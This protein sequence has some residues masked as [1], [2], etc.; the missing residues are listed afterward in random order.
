MSVRNTPSTRIP[1][2]VLK[3]QPSSTPNSARKCLTGIPTLIPNRQSFQLEQQN[4]NKRRE[5]YVTERRRLTDARQQILAI[6]TNITELQLKLRQLCESDGVDNSAVDLCVDA[7]VPLASS[8][9]RDCQLKD[10]HIESLLSERNTVQAK[11]KIATDKLNTLLANRIVHQHNLQETESSHRLELSAAQLEIDEFAAQLKRVIAKLHSQHEREMSD[12]GQTF[13]ANIKE[14]SD[15]VPALK[16]YNRP[17]DLN[18]MDRKKAA[19]HGNLDAEVQLMKSGDIAA[20][21]NSL[22][23]HNNLLAI[24]SQLIVRMQTQDDAMRQQLA[25]V[26]AVNVAHGVEQQLLLGALAERETRVEQQART[27]RRMER[28]RAD[29]AEL[30]VSVEERMTMLTE[31]NQRLRGQFQ[32]FDCRRVPGTTTAATTQ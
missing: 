19:M 24:R 4:A 13:V 26:N 15:G 20:L 28:E 12:A 6:H 32:F 30:L 21:Q 25:T 3:P 18:S 31:E 11:M 5:S 8:C 14:L 17:I 29:H 1:K 16:A 2:F 22:T 7:A 27:I 10:Y 9:C 23:V